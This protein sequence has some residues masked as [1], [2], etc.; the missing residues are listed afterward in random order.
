LI[1]KIDAM[2]EDMANT[3]IIIVGCQNII[4]VNINSSLARLIDGGAEMLIARKIN[5]QNVKFGKIFVSP[6]IDIMFRVWYLE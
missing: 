2:N 5:H 1:E 6:L 3:I 4:L